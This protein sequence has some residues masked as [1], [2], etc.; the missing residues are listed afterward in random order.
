MKRK[1]LWS[2]QFVK[3]L[4]WLVFAA[5]VAPD[6]VE[7]INLKPAAQDS[8]PLEWSNC[9][10]WA[11]K[12]Q[13]KPQESCDMEVD[14]SAQDMR[15]CLLEAERI[16]H[17]VNRNSGCL[18]EAASPSSTAERRRFRR[19]HGQIHAKL[20]A[21]APVALC[22]W[23][24]CS[25]GSFDVAQNHRGNWR[26]KYG[27]VWFSTQKWSKYYD[28]VTPLWELYVSVSGKLIN[29]INWTF[30]SLVDGFGNLF[31]LPSVYQK[32]QLNNVF[33][34]GLELPS[35]SGWPQYPRV[36]QNLMGKK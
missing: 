20:A 10:V 13:A 33:G 30:G 36:P 32:S 26:V 31:Y 25:T 15:G 16:S 8:G 5:S 23:M 6:G 14:F 22:G 12:P 18:L 3:I 1:S 27:L 17:K 21:M 4:W 34:K 24:G 35:S 29:S 7:S 2:P 19:S 9:E 28:S 11:M